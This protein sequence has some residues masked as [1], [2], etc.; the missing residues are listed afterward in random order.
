AIYNER[1]RVI[2]WARAGAPYPILARPGES[3]RHLF[4]EGPLLGVLPAAQ[5]EVDELQLEPGDTLLFHTDGLDALLL[6]RHPDLG[7]CDLDRTEWFQSLGQAPIE[8]LFARLE[9]ELGAVEQSERSRDDIT[10]VALHVQEQAP[11][12]L[13]RTKHEAAPVAFCATG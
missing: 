9:N 10:A 13:S 3:P 12:E 11:I 4:T 1:T 7:C 2:R 8:K 5:F 6:N